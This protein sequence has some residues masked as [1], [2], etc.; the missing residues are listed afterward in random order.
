MWAL[1][2]VVVDRTCAIDGN[3]EGVLSL[4][5]ATLGRNDEAGVERVGLV[6]G[7]GNLVAGLD[8]VVLAGV[9]VCCVC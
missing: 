8:Y 3:D 6:V 4:A 2:A 9:E 1:G 5:T 7:A